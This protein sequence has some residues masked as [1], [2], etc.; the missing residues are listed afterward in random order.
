MQ[1]KCKILVG[2]LY[3]F[4]SKKVKIETLTIRL[5]LMSIAK[6]TYISIQNLQHN[7]L[8]A[9]KPFSPKMLQ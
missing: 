8:Q 3:K 2:H 6:I 4:S 9:F 7:S 1:Q 5:T